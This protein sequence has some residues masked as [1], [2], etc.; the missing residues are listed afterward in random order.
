MSKRDYYEV[1]GV[2]KSAD[3]NTIKKAYRKLAM[4][5][6][7][8]RNPD[9]KEA[10]A[11]FKEASEA[12]EILLDDDKRRKYDQFGHAGVNGQAGGFGQGGFS[13]FGDIFSDIFGGGFEDIF[14]GGRRRGGRSRARAGSDLQMQLNVSFKD[15]AFGIE[16]KI[17]ITRNISCKTCNG[18]GAKAGSSPV[19][20]DMCHGTGEIR[21]Q[22]GFFTMASTCP[23]CHGAGEMIKDPCGTCHGQGVT[24]KK[25]ELEVS[26]PAGIDHGQ[27]LKLS[28]EGDAGQNG[29]P[30]GDLYVVVAIEDDEFFQ[31]D[32]FDVYC[33][34][35]ISFSQ[36]ALGADIEVPT[37]DGKVEV[38]I[39]EG[40]QSGRK[41]RLKGKGITKLG[42]YGKG[43][44]IIEVH[45]ET[46]T[47]LSSEQR[48]I[49]QKLSDMEHV[50]SNPMSKGF[51]DKVR[52]L[53]Q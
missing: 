12:A 8:D 15:A 37:L 49:F 11:K 42:G 32:G 21:R 33:K 16:R 43:D 1:L 40:T 7:P 28:G 10:E 9:N 26:I 25:V 13:D 39:S 3:K 4:Q 31:R 17:E 41:M 45:V 14:G 19:S 22:Q 38:K 51:F 6:H 44:Q 35:P 24:K 50:K 5:Y 29:G 23:K 18:S 46:P 52:D 2:S 20:C 36:A 53:F 48:E 27:R 34:V 30:S 47:K